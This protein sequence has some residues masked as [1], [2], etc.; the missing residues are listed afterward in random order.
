MTSINN[1]FSG[2]PKFYGKKNLPDTKIT[3]EA[4]RVQL[5]KEGEN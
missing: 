3:K 4:D 2:T 5:T 1:N